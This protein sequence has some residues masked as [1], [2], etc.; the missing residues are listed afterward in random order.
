MFW[1]PINKY[2]YIFK[3]SHTKYQDQ[4]LYVVFKSEQVQIL[5]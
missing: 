1:E 5:A 3:Q 4:V 2:E